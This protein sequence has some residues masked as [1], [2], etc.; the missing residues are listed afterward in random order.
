MQF[1][2][3]SQLK[4]ERGKFL[5]K[6]ETR[7]KTNRKEHLETHIKQRVPAYWAIGMLWM[8]FFGTSAY[9]VLFSP[10]LALN[11]PQI[12][13]L[14][15]IK[16]ADFQNVLQRE[17]DQKYYGLF[18]RNRYFLVQSKK[19]VQKL[20]AAYPLIRTLEVTPYFPDRLTILIEE[21]EALLLWCSA[22]SCTHILE[23]GSTRPVTDVYH[24]EENRSRTITLRDLSEQPL[25]ENGK[26]FDTEFVSLPATLRRSL[27]EVFALETESEMSLSSRFANELRVKTRDGFEIYFSTRI[28]LETSLEA[29]HLIFEKEISDERRPALQYI[30]LRTENRVFYRYKEGEETESVVAEEKKEDE[31]KEKSDSDKKKK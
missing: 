2:W 11:I 14:E 8:L 7:T 25:P 27:Q 9:L 4:K 12:V 5:L 6:K 10:Y 20:E 17:L 30:D 16:A 13:G 23:N 21:R 28:P 24:E 22:D 1:L 3:K 26:V 29:L 18:E 15:R 19:L 31:K